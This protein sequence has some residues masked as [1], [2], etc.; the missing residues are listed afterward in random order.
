[1][2]LMRPGTAWYVV[3]TRSRFE[4][5]VQEGLLK[6]SFDVFLPKVL[7]RSRRRDRRVMLRVPLFPGYLFVHST[8]DPYAQVDILKTTGAV[9]LIGSR[10]GPVPVPPETI[11]SLRIMVAADQPIATSASLRPG[12]IV[13]V[14]ARPLTGV[15]GRFLRYRGK[16][17]VVVHIEALGQYAAVEV[18]ASQVERVIGPLL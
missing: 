9:R 3:H 2:T 5:V 1:M 18:D 16:D 11:A 4:S 13:V 8:L 15:T 7:A 6:K 10:D 14:I 17:R 12:E